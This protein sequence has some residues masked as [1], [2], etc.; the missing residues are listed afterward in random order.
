MALGGEGLPGATWRSETEAD[1]WPSRTANHRKRAA[2]LTPR[3][4]RLSKAKGRAG[5]S[6]PTQEG[7][8]HGGAAAAP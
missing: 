4:Q 1:R 3:A 5:S 6:S 8:Y 2:G 7:P